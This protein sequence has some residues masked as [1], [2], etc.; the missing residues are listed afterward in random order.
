MRPSGVTSAA[1]AAAASVDVAMWAPPLRTEGA[2]QI[3]RHTLIRYYSRLRYRHAK[4][5]T[6]GL[7]AFIHREMTE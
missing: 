2:G 5:R 3:N 6:C 1:A 4:T 7:I